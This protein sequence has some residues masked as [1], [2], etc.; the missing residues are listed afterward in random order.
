MTNKYDKLQ[1]ELLSYGLTNGS[2]LGRHMG[3]MDVAAEAIEDL[4]THISRFAE[5]HFML[6]YVAENCFDEE[7]CR[8]QLRMLWTAYC[9]HHGLEADTSGYDTDLLELWNKL[10]ETGDG[11]SDWSDFDSFDNFMCTYLV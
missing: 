2:V 10:T 4:E 5:F 11:A 7:I 1:K 8:D 9:L 6:V 3:I